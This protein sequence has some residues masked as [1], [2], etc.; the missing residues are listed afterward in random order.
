MDDLTLV[1]GVYQVDHDSRFPAQIGTFSSRLNPLYLVAV[2]VES[3]LHLRELEIGIL[4][5]RCDLIP[6]VGSQ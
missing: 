4:K 5:G 6:L 2:P 3:V 1:G